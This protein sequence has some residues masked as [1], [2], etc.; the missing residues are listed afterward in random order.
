MGLF[1]TFNLSFLVV[2]ILFSNNIILFSLIVISN[3]HHR[4]DQIQQITGPLSS[5]T[6]SWGTPHRQQPTSLPCLIWMFNQPKYTGWITNLCKCCM[7]IRRDV[8]FQRIGIPTTY[9]SCLVYSIT[10]N[11]NGNRWRTV[12]FTKL[13]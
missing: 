9:I 4:F 2:I 13:Y 6:R 7:E 8:A 10:L 3:F 12:Q 5:S 11:W 1:D